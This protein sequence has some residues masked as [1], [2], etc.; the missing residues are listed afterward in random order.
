VL[1]LNSYGNIEWQKAIGGSSEDFL[2]AVIQT[3]DGGYFLGGYS[4]SGISADK[5]EASEGSFDYWVVKLD[6]AGNIEWQNTIGGNLFDQLNSVIQTADSGYLIGGYSYSGISGDKTEANVNP[7]YSDYWVVKLDD[8]G[9]IEWQ[10]TIGGNS[11]DQLWW[12]IESA[13]SGYLLGGNSNSGI[14]GDKTEASY[15]FDDYWVVKL[16]DLG[17]IQWQNTI[18]GNDFDDLYSGIQ[19]ADGGYLLGGSSYSTISGD[20][21]EA[22]NGNDYWVVRINSS[23]NIEWQNTIGGSQYDELHSVIQTSD[24]GYLIGGSSSSGIS[25]DK[26]EIN[27]GD[28]DY[29]VIKLDDSGS[30]EWQNTLGG[31]YYDILTSIIQAAEGGYLLGG[32]SNSGI[33]GDKTEASEGYYDYWVIKLFAEESCKIPSSLL[34]TDIT[35]SSTKLLWDA[36]PEALGYKLRYKVT[37]ASDWTTTHSTENHKKLAAL[38]SNTEYVWQV[39]SICG[40]N[41]IV[42]SE[43]SEKQFFTTSSLKQ[44]FDENP[45]LDIY[46]N[47]FS[48]STTISFS[49]LQDGNAT[50][51]LYDLA[52]R[53]IETVLDENVEA[54][55]HKVQLTRGQWSGGIYFLKMKLNES[56]VTTKI[57]IQ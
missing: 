9:N 50:I 27:K 20:K 30:I 15:G 46:P 28:E 24:G 37:G 2:S 23:G 44:A 56:I 43:W 12:I 18:G 13:D 41:P 51:T 53:K 8:S 4:S 49:L 26:T 47:P 52:G 19:A 34:V 1:K 17:N 39:K 22:S 5:T 14:S 35:Q 40:V 21:T 48:S 57:I 6:N 16:N 36:V 11:D 54:G 38:T 31:S 7:D 29:W 25:G 32:F 55:S 10:N 33:S 42:S 45:L 3:T